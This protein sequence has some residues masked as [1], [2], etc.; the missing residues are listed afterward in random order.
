MHSFHHSRGRIFFE[1]LCALTVSGSCVLAW[2][3][4]GATAFLPA[5]FAAALY[6]LWH[7]TDMR[8]PRPAVAVEAAVPAM[9]VEDEGDLLEYAQAAQAEPIAYQAPEPVAAEEPKPAAKPKRKSRKKQAAIE[10]APA[11]WPVVTRTDENPAPIAD[12]F[13]AEEEHHPPLAPLFEPQPLVRQQRAVFG[14]KS[15]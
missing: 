10:E 4:T 14:R 8:R 2:E 1:V 7:L 9:T 5:A 15:G 6:G 12:P 13:D 11:P 3:Q